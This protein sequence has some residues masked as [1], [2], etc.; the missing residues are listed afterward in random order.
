MVKEYIKNHPEVKT[1]MKQKKARSQ[2]AEEPTPVVTTEAKPAKKKTP[3]AP[4][5]ETERVVSGVKL[6]FIQFVAEGDNDSDSDSEEV[7]EEAQPAPAPAPVK[8]PSE[9]SHSSGYESDDSDSDSSS[10][11]EEKTKRVKVT[12]TKEVKLHSY[13]NKPFK[14]G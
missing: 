9:D 5:Q 3:V 4:A 8:E 1:A 11:S 14:T 6:P 12:E 13:S 10:E 7:K 2:A